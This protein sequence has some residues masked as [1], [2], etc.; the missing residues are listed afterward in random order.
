MSTFAEHIMQFINAI[1]NKE[2]SRN[3]LI[4]GSTLNRKVYVFARQS[5]L[6]RQILT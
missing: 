2:M 4:N 1:G 3:I 6:R 5:E